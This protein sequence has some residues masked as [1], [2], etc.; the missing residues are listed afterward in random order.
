MDLLHKEATNQDERMNQAQFD[1]HP[2]GS[3]IRV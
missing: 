1:L 3:A 2:G